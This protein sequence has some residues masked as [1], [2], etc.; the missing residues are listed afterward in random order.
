M[1]CLLKFMIV[2]NMS[3]HLGYRIT[4]AIVPLKFDSVANVGNLN[5]CKSPS[6]SPEPPPNPPVH[7]RFCQ[8]H[9]R[10]SFQIPI[11]QCSWRLIDESK[12]SKFTRFVKNYVSQ[13]IL[14]S[15]AR[16]SQQRFDP[17]LTFAS[18]RE[19]VIFSGRAY[20]CKLL[21]QRKYF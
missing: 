16:S 6:W 18:R 2:V 10:T 15:V 9:V 5:S 21:D 17:F 11:R 20:N 4:K 19:C 14:K 7:V 12:M 1:F 8:E 13:V 3:P